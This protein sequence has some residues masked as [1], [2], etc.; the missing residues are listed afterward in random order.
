MGLRRRCP[1]L[2]CFQWRK[3][4]P[5]Q[6]TGELRQKSLRCML[7]FCVP[8]PSSTAERE[9]CFTCVIF[10]EMA[11]FKSGLWCVGIRVFSLIPLINPVKV[12]PRPPHKV[13]PPLSVQPPRKPP[14]KSNTRAIL[15]L[16][17]ST[18]WGGKV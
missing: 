5:S 2:H 1:I 11:H 10:H 12:A 16:G 4:A 3:K 13:A 7:K 18:E 17:K 14:T 8:V 6:F 9:L 15:G